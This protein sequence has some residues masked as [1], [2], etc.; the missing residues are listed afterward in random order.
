MKEI[1][2]NQETKFLLLV[3]QIILCG[4]RQVIYKSQFFYSIT[5]DTMETKNFSKEPS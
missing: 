3:H 1:G 2:E 5:S 4:C